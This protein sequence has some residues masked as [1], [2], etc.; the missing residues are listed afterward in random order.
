[1]EHAAE[2]A[3]QDRCQLLGPDPSERCQ[4]FRQRRESADVGED[5]AAVD[6]TM[7]LATREPSERGGEP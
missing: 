4:S 1:L 7:P 3:I 6:R 5:Q 2:D